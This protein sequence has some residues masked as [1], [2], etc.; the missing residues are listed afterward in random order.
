MTE[1]EIKDHEFLVGQVAA[2]RVIS[3][4]LARH[5]APTEEAYQLLLKAVEKTPTIQDPSLD[6]RRGWDQMCQGFARDL[7]KSFQVIS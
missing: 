2:L 1:Q 6:V 7:L 4:T 5:L 3:L